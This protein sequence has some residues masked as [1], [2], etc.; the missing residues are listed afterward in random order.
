MKEKSNASLPNLINQLNSCSNEEM[1]AI[2]KVCL[3][4]NIEI[5]NFLKF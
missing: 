1:I 4:V 2:I 5:L 3:T